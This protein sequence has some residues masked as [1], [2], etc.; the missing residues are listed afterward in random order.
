MGVA[1]ESPHRPFRCDRRAWGVWLALLVAVMPQA[2]DLERVT[3]PSRGNPQAS[4]DAELEPREQGP[5]LSLTTAQQPRAQTAGGATVAVQRIFIRGASVFQDEDFDAVRSRYQGR[6]LDFA[7]L[8]AL[9]D[10]ITMM[11]VERGYLTSGAVLTNLV[12]GVLGVEV[13]EGRLADIE[14]KND[15]RLNDAFVAEW[16]R[17]FSSSESPVNVFTLERHLQMLQQDPGI[18]RVDARL[19]PSRS[20]GESVLEVAPLEAR[21]FGALIALSNHVA[22]AVGGSQVS[23]R[24]DYANLAGRTDNIHGAVRAAEGLTEIA[25]EYNAPMSARQTRFSVYGFG[26]DSEIVSG[27]F[28]HLDIEAESRTVGARIEHPVHRSLQRRDLVYLTGELRRS[29]TYLLGSRFSF[30]PGPEQ[31]RAKLTVLRTGWEHTQRWQRSALASRLE[32]SVGLDAFDAT[33][34]APDAAPGTPDGQFA[35]V[36]GQLQ[37]LRRLSW[38]SSQV[39][40]RVAGQTT[41]DPLLAIEQLQLGGRY[42]VRGYRENTLIRDRGVVASVDWRVPI[43]RNRAAAALL[44]IGPFVD[45]SY[46]RNDAGDEVGPRRLASAGLGLRW[47]PVSSAEI[48][49]YWG[50]AFDELDYAGSDALQDDGFHIRAWWSLAR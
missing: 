20:R 36:L 12:D 29:T 14:V 4:L 16:L 8:T 34:A 30:V 6:A 33:S 22:P 9:R 37:W 11:Y 46:S 27:P 28:D 13:I 10:D 44:E 18:S 2:A 40:V 41:T 43:L 35:S 38:L 23:A 48:E 7:D 19:L 45:W 1:M 31:G 26:S 24:F 50:H 32:L 17:G 15:G 39:I 21:A 3:V 47:A 5:T 25:V 49:V 42:T